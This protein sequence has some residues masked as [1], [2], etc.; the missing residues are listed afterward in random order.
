M[1]V[2]HNKDT[3]YKSLNYRAFQ[4]RLDFRF[5]F[6]YLFFNFSIWT[7]MPIALQ[8]IVAFLTII[9]AL[10]R[11]AVRY[12]A[13]PRDVPWAGKRGW[14]LATTLANVWDLWAA[15]E[16]LAEGYEKVGKDG[17]RPSCSS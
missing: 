2:E 14:F 3:K 16:N 5:A 12:R 10:H 17:T 13:F 1:L 15:R 7:D 8:I 11:Y 6:I 4:H 9:Y